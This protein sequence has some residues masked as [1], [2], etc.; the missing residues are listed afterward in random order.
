MDENLMIGYLLA[1][2]ARAKRDDVTP[3]SKPFEYGLFWRFILLL[4]AVFV[5]FIIAATFVFF[6]F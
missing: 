5:A 3:K 4:G 1:N 6:V 2:N